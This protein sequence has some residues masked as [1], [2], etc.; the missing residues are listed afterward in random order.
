M[1]KW[2]LRFESER[3]HEW[4]SRYKYEDDLP[5]IEIG[6]RARQAGEFSYQDFLVVCEWKTPRTRSRCRKNNPE[7]ISEVT[8]ISLSTAIERL[9][10]EVLQC[11]HGVGWPTASVLFHFAHNDPYPI[12]DVRALWSLGFEKPVFYSFRF[13]WQYVQTCRDI[14]HQQGVD[15][16][17]LDRALWQYS[18][19]NQPTLNE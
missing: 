19:E 11:L 9:R 10:I 12:L 5:I 17:T 8:R 13:W 3:I 4:A 7:E 18:K 14:A 16:R 1:G 6:R 15:M 2:Q